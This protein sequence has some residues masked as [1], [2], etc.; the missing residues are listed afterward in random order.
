VQ[1]FQSG[2]RH[3]CDSNGVAE[4]AEHRCGRST[5]LH[6]IAAAQAVFGNVVSESSICAASFAKVYG[7]PR[8]SKRTVSYLSGIKV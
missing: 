8:S 2:F 7:V 5:N 1:R 6:D 4:R 3:G